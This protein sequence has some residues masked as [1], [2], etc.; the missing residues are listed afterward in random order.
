ML[1]RFKRK[2]KNSLRFRVLKMGDTPKDNINIPVTL[3]EN[4]NYILNLSPRVTSSHEHISLFNLSALTSG[5]IIEIGSYLSYSSVMMASAFSSD[6][7]KL[8]AIDMFDRELG[9]SNGGTDDWIYKNYSQWE[10]AHK[11][12]DDCGLSNSIELLKGRSDQLIN[13]MIELTDVNMI[14][15]DGDH[16]YEGCMQDIENYS[17]ILNSGGFL[18]VDDYSDT[19]WSGVKKAVDE[20][21]KINPNYIPVYFLDQMLVLKKI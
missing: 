14:F 2:I 13:K 21:I 19:Q 9:W 6:D 8:Y 18:V 12:I 16:S 11:V 15:I 1:N 7:R 3:N 20:F 17:P 10:F 5:D 4:Y